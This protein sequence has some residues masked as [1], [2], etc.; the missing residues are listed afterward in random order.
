MKQS[1]KRM[2]LALWANRTKGSADVISRLAHDLNQPLSGINLFA[3]NILGCLEDKLPLEEE[4]IIDAMRRI[5]KQVE[6]VSDRID[7][8]RDLCQPLDLASAVDLDVRSVAHEA[9]R[10]A[11]PRFASRGV[12][13]AFEEPE[14]P[15]I[16]KIGRHPL[17]T[18]LSAL[19]DNALQ[20]VVA[21]KR[22]SGRVALTIRSEAQSGKTGVCEM[23]VEDDGPGVPKEVRERLDDP[24]RVA[25]SLRRGVG[26]GLAV[27]NI[28]AVEFGGEFE[29]I[30]PAEGGTR[31]VVR[32]PLSGY[33][34]DS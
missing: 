13:F 28:V 4:E 9:V 20:A 27:V 25:G 15:V 19:L 33:G 18:I 10:L 8:T 6:R 5:L 30:S 22:E 29:L 3:E 16:V 14:N 24:L 34:R 32:L 23:A 11:D 21:M 12:G 26:L 31:A 2:V 1:T 17:M 7:Q